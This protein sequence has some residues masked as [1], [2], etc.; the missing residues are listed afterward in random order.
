VIL[1]TS[2]QSKYRIKS[3]Q[4]ERVVLTGPRT[5]EETETVL[6]T[7]S[8]DIEPDE[9]TPVSIDDDGNVVGL[10]GLSELMRWSDKEGAREKL[11]D[12]MDV[13][14]PREAQALS[15]AVVPNADSKPALETNVRRSSRRLK[16]RR[17]QNTKLLILGGLLMVVIGVGTFF[18]IQLTQQASET[19][20]PADDGASAQKPEPPAIKPELPT[21]PSDPIVNKPV[22]I[23]PETVYRFNDKP[24]LNPDPQFVPPWLAEADTPPCDVPTVLTP[25]QAIEFEGWYVMSPPRGPADAVGDTDVQLGELLPSAEYNGNRLLS[26]TVQNRSASTLVQGEMHIMLLDSTGRVFAET[27]T[28]LIMIPP[29]GDH[30][31][32]LPIPTRWWDRARGVRAGAEAVQW[33]DGT[34]PLPDV[35]VAPL[36]TEEDTVVRVSVRNPGEKPLRGVLILLEATDVRGKPIAQFVISEKNLDVQPERWL[37]LVVATP[38]RAGADT[39]RWSATVQPQ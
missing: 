7:D 29:G 9:V 25:G 38:I 11:R 35:R 34:K 21:V 4:I 30:S 24:S 22:P 8:V 3:S 5:L 16:K 6:R 15:E 14:K 2:C 12:Q 18:L 27:F 39:V 20:E 36:G 32:T 19:Q 17:Q 37:D 31:L 26:G 23:E 28:P 13:H 10:S 33:S 1:C